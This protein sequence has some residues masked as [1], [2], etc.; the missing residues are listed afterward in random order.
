LTLGAGDVTLPIMKM[1]GARMKRLTE[2]PAEYVGEGPMGCETD[3]E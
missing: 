2:A 1:L 3:Q